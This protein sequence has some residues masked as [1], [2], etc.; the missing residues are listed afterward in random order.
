MD[1][2]VDAVVALVDEDGGAVFGAADLRA[3]LARTDREHDA[4]VVVQRGRVVGWGRV[5]DDGR[6][7]RADVAPDAR[8]QGIG[9]W[10]LKWSVWRA[11]SH[12]AP[13]VGQTLD[14]RR[15]AVAAWFQGMGY[16]PRYGAWELQGPAPT[17][18]GTGSGITLD[19]VAGRSGGRLFAVRR[20]GRAVGAA[21]LLGETVAPSDPAAVR[22]VLD[23][24]RDGDP[25]GPPPTP[26]EA[27]EA[28][29][30][31]GLTVH[32]SFTHWAVDVAGRR[33]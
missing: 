9:T 13:H 4:V 30:G 8:G 16:T 17:G 21:Y 18:D 22:E 12:G 7:C 19:P 31:L 33:S 3:T 27:R 26:A 23:A 29:R 11:Q 20:D 6:E 5:T 25:Q 24:A 32:T 14:D 10:L 28:F 15:T 1:R 2:D